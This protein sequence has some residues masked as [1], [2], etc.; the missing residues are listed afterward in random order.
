M[1]YS[2]IPGESTESVLVVETNG[3]V[4]DL[5]SA[6]EDLT[7]FSDLAFAAK[8]TEMSI[9]EI[10]QD[11]L[12]AATAIGKS[13]VEGNRLLPVVPEEVWAAGVTYRISEEAREKESESADVYMDVYDADRPELFFKATPSRLSAPN[14]PVGI[15]KDSS[16]NVPE[17]ELGLVL[18]R[19][20]VVGFTLG[21]D[22]SSRSIEGENPLYLPQAKIYDKSC[23]IGPSIVTKAEGFDPSNAEIG[24]KIFREDSI[25][26]NG[27]ASTSEMVRSFDRLVNYYAKHDNPPKWGVLLTG[28]TIVPEDEFTL[29]EGDKIE[30]TIDEIGTLTNTVATV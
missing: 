27:S 21:N 19:D 23:S 6:N 12:D 8:V 1:R 2:R 24:M 22:M 11:L 20:E 9:D 16:W 3:G 10:T 4:Y 28:T 18:H 25:V 30:I 5:T 14:E 7:G 29:Q 26:F 13:V 15:R 17:P